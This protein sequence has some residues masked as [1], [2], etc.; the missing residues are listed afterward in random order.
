MDTV[1][2]IHQNMNGWQ[3]HCI[4]KG[5]SNVT[6]SNATL[7]VTQPTITCSTPVICAGSGASATLTA[8]GATSGSYTWSTGDNTD[9]IVETP[10]VT[11]TYTVS[12]T[13]VT[14]TGCSGMNTGTI[15]VLQPQVPAICEVTTDS[16][17]NY[18]YNYIYW[19]ASAY[20]RVDSFVIYRYDGSSGH[21]LRIGS[22]AKDSLSVFID[23][24]FSVGGPNGGNPQ[25]GA[26]K[27]KLSLRDS[28]GNYS[29][30]GSY[31][32]TTFVQE[33]GSNFS[34]TL[35]IDSNNTSLPTGYAFLRDDNNT[36]NFHSLATLGNTTNSTT[37]PNY[38]SFPNAN[39]R[40]DALGF[41]CTPTTARLSGNNSVDAAK[42]KSH[43][44]TNNNRG[45]TTGINKVLNTNQVSVYPNPANNVLNIAFPITSQLFIKITSILGS[46]ILN[47]TYNTTN[48]NL[49]LDISKYESGT[50]LIQI[51]TDN[52]SEIKKI[53]KQ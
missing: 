44:N 49:I 31:H 17:T 47:Q 24:A 36:G 12:G 11:T 35:Y 7:T 8:S 20:S 30:L 29:A 27:Y 3:Y 26:W 34:W 14:G 25:Y 15:T 19:D 28:C 6:S 2:V 33:T 53:V 48:T 5:C 16:T 10:T 18:K 51:T 45:M 37:D 39:W 41:N 43:S 21:Y 52:F 50:Y 38:A 4:V 23:T 32:S 22:R 42:V 46:E 13:D 1:S 40:V 9:F